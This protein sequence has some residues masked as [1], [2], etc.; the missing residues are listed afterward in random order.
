MQCT[1]GAR[2][3]RRAR[4]SAV[5][6]GRVFSGARIS[7]SLRRYDPDQ[8]RRVGFR[9]SA[10][11]RAPR[12]IAHVKVMRRPCAFKR[13]HRRRARLLCRYGTQPILQPLPAGPRSNH[14]WGMTV[15]RANVAATAIAASVAASVALAH[16]GDMA[17]GF[18]GG[19]RHPLLGVDH[20]VAMVAVGLWGAFLGAPAI[21]LLPIV[22]PLVMAGGG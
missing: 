16:T 2:P 7:K 18:F 12:E 20:V 8:V 17:G 15:S 14:R 9:L 4:I 19:V 10:Q 5:M 11:R 1:R 22:F 13:R 21:W 3:R 6:A